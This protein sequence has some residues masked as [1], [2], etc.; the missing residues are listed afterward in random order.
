VPTREGPALQ[1]LLRN[2]AAPRFNSGIAQIFAFRPVDGKQKPRRE[3][4]QAQSGAGCHFQTP[5]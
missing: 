1:N 3:G 4:S 2:A 5:D